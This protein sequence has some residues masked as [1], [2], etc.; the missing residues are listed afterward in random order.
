MTER[1]LFNIAGFIV[2]VNCP[3]E[4]E[5]VNML[6]SFLPFRFYDERTIF[7]Y[8]FQCDVLPMTGDVR[9]EGETLLEETVNDMGTVRL[10]AR[11]GQ[12]RLALAGGDGSLMRFMLADKDFS[13]LKI[14]LDRSDRESGHALSSLLRIAY[15]QAILYNDSL[16][17]HA[18]AVFR[19]GRSYLFMGKSGTGKSTH[20]RLWMEH[21]PGTGLLNDDNPTV[22]VMSGKAYA[23]GTPWSGKTPC[24]RPWFF[25]VGGMVRLVLAPENRFALQEGGDAFVAIYPGCSVIFQD[26]ELRD[27]LYDTVARLAGRV[28]VGTL[29]CKPE[30]DA[31]ILCHESLLKAQNRT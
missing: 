20:A 1:H 18:S 4:W 31:A 14:Y 8:L 17:I 10:Y 29:E 26:A 13:T 28:P 11:S 16:A 19:E 12:Y 3:E 25:P 9:T 22:R 27:R 30:K 21:I 2:A 7:R 5:L 24:Y 23:F 6:P 15:S